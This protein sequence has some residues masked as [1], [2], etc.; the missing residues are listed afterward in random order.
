MPILMGKILGLPP[1]DLATWVGSFVVA[2]TFVI[3]VYGTFG[4][5]DEIK[6]Q[7]F[8]DR[9]SQARLVGG[10]IDQSYS[11]R[12]MSGVPV[13]TLTV[14]N[15]S[16]LAI[17]RVRGY[18]FTIDQASLV[19]EF[20]EIPVLR[21][22]DDSR[23]VYGEGMGGEFK[24]VLIYDDDAGVRWRKYSTVPLEVIEADNPDLQGLI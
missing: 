18:L 3:L 20:A 21:P 22:G 16:P 24:L 10:W 1:G 9:S 19:A 23:E 12:G 8:L 14:Q 4:Q 13:V 5:H 2:I 6:R 11:V 7:I 15:A 17:R